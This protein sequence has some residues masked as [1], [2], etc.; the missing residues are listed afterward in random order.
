MNKK[1]LR[2]SVFRSNK[3]LYVQI[4]DDQKGHTLVSASDKDLEP[5]ALKKTKTEKAGMVGAILAE[6]A[7]KKK[8]KEVWFDRRQY[9]YHGRIKALAEAA[10]KG[11]LSF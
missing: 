4:I 6:R 2:I 9:K 3:Y 1:R 5:A 11:G 7:L 10:R 8:I